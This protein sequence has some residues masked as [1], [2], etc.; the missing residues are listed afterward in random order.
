MR[1]VP[2]PTTLVIDKQGVVR[3]KVV[4]IDYR[5]RPTNEDILSALS[6]LD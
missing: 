1:P 5:M 3:W 2:H 4:E 6:A